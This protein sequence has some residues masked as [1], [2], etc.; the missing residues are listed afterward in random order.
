MCGKA[1]NL[2]LQAPEKFQHPIFNPVRDQTWSLGLLWSL[3]VGDWRFLPAR[4]ALA[5]QDELVYLITR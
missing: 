5:S 1:P 2:K 3:D 4:S